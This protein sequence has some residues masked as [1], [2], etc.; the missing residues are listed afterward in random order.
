MRF[1]T[2]LFLLICSLQTIAQVS[3]DSIS[4]KNDLA[5]YKKTLEETHPSLY[6]FSSKEKFDSLFNLTKSNLDKK[7]TELDFF[8]AISKLSSLVREGHSYIQPTKSLSSSIQNKSLFPFSVLVEDSCITVQDSR[9]AELA[10]LKKA[11]IYSINGQSVKS[12]LKSLSESTCMV[13]AFNNSGLKSRLSLYNNFAFAYYYFIDTTSTFNI[14]FRLISDNK[15]RTATIEGSSAQ[16]SG[17]NYPQL[18]ADP[19]PPFSLEINEQ[20]STAIMSIST[21]AYW[22]VGKKIKD[23]SKFFKKSFTSI[24]NQ[25]IKNLIIDVRGNR[26]GEEM[27]AG[28][29]L[30]YLIDYEFRI[31]KYS[32]ANSLEFDFIN[33][34]PNS[35]QIKLSKSNYIVSDSGFVMKRADFLKEYVP[36]KKNQ[37][38]GNVYLL[39]N[40]ICASACHIFLALIKTHKVG[41]I[42]GQES[43]GAFEDVDGRQR[44]KFTLPYSKIF[45]SY[46]TWAM[47]LNTSGGDKRRG[48]IPDYEVFPTIEDIALGKDV[49][50]E[51]AL[52][53]I[54]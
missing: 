7:T 16:L 37:F 31:Y 8:R 3:T 44:I 54:R 51:L 40:G 33:S 53:L 26:G 29:L 48:V 45:V 17:K 30:T 10:Y 6:R 21:F 18:P 34:L 52:K 24:Q 38:K 32:K 23:Y 46:P 49:E 14:D 15:I 11:V 2:I 1:S 20:R 41:K 12:I 13:S 19:I 36:Q 9:S 28:E 25:K 27:I 4:Y 22:A 50:M 39:S 43:G 47:K 5:I 42:I 35:N